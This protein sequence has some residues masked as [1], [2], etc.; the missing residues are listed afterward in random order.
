[1]ERFLFLNSHRAKSGVLEGVQLPLPYVL[2][3]KFF[4]CGVVDRT[5]TLDVGFET[6]VWSPIPILKS[7]A[8]PFGDVCDHVA[9]AIL[10]RA[11]REEKSV[12]VM[13]SGGIDSTCA[14]VALLQAN[15]SRKTPIRL[16]VLLT[17]ESIDEYP[18]FFREFILNKVPYTVVAAPVTRWLSENSLVVT[19]EHGDQLFGSDK[20]LGLIENGLAFQPYQIGLEMILMDKFRDRTHT[21]TV[22]SYLEPLLDKSPY[23]IS[24]AMDMFWWLNFTLKW[25]QVSL[26]LAV[27]HGKDVRP[28]IDRIIHF[29]GDDRFQM[30]SMQHPDQ[31]IKESLSTYKFP[32]KEYIYAFT[33]DSGYLDHKK[34]QP[35]LKN[36]ILDR[37]KQ[38]PE[39]Y[40]V[41]MKE[42][43]L[44]V[45]E[46]FHK[47]LKNQIIDNPIGK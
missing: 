22:M 3:S 44:P 33:S 41:H 36:I 32:A 18:S 8:S 42:D 21:S 7:T 2:T 12:D 27:F 19:G 38:G 17:I 30:W 14:L 46:T 47:R 1:M 24:T 11:D 13:W 20:V 6:K 45:I 15:H 10:D 9:E 4:D 25:Q 43:Y 23:P 5:G 29:F 26:R 28:M 39:R 34:K 31:K 16:N 37:K 40:R 35:S